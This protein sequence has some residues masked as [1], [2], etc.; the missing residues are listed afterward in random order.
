[1]GCYEEGY[2][3]VTFCVC[4]R[5][6]CVCVVCV[7]VHAQG[8]CF[9]LGLAKDAK[10]IALLLSLVKNFCQLITFHVFSKLTNNFPGKHFIFF[11]IYPIILKKNALGNCVLCFMRQKLPAAS[12]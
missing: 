8:S 3:H 1:M 10:K 5:V 7:C 9:L 6:L 12:Q 2:S 11:V 4:V